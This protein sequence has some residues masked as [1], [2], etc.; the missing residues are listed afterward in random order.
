MTFVSSHKDP[1]ALSIVFVSEFTAPVEQVW[2]VWED[3]RK[4][5]RWWGPPTYPATYTTYEF[6][7]GGRARYFMTGPEGQRFFGAWEITLVEAPVRLEF[8]DGF[9]DES[10]AMI[11]EPHAP[12][13]TVVTLDPIESGTRMTITTTFSD[14]ASLE[15]IGEM[16][17]VEGM[18]EALG[19]IDALL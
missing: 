18:T 9:A 11:S 10:G 14:L 1:E 5:E 16:G 19:Q 12:F 3:P 4:L 13:P 8:V 15:A 17:M 6:E 7:K 2:Q